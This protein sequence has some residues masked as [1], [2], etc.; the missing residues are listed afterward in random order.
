[1]QPVRLVSN[2]FDCSFPRE[3]M[4][5]EGIEELVNS[6]RRD[7]LID[8][9]SRDRKVKVMSVATFRD[10]QPGTAERVKYSLE[11]KPNQQDISYTLHLEVDSQSKEVEGR[12]KESSEP[13]E[14]LRNVRLVVRVP[15]D[16]S[17]PIEGVRHVVQQYASRLMLQSPESGSVRDYFTRRFGWYVS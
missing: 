16:G 4:R 5:G 6:I 3:N 13:S 10:V 8:V 9:S 11:S 7:G 12:P 17:V 1:M 15:V 2:I 14:Q